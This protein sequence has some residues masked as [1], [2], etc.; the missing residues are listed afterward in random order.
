M[1]IAYFNSTTAINGTQDTILLIA[2]HNVRCVFVNI[3][4]LI[5]LYKLYYDRPTS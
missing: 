3:S 2:M 1:P 5:E 4:F